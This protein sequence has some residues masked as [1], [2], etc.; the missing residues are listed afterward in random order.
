MINKFLIFILL[1]YLFIILHEGCHLIIYCFCRIRIKR[2][3][4]FPFD[5]NFING[6]HFRISK[7]WYLTGGVF[8][9]FETINKKEKKIIFI[10][11]LSAPIMHFMLFSIGLFAFLKTNSDVFFNI[12]SINLIMLLSTLTENSRAVGDLI[13]AYYIFTSNIKAEK[14]YKGLI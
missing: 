3:Y 6:F 11:L 10:S 2:F 1:F 5:L 4:I 14:I 9:A 7:C 12:T 8:P 13:A